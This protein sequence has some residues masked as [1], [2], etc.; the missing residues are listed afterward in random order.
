[1]DNTTKVVEPN[2]TAWYRFEYTGDHSQID[3]E[4]PDAIL[5]GVERGLAFEV[6]A[7]SQMQEWWK[8]D[9]VGAGS[10]K[11]DDLVWSG[12]SHEPGTWWIK[13]MNTKPTEMPFNLIVSGDKVSFGPPTEPVTAVTLPSAGALIENAVPDMAMVVKAN[14][15]VIPGNTTAWYRFPYQGG[16]DQIMLKIPN[17]ADKDLGVYI[18]TPE[19]VKEWWS[20]T[21]VGAATP[22]DGDLLWSGNAEEAGTGTS[23]WSTI[24]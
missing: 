7:P 8:Y 22:K 4:L 3:I 20:A 12:N 17:G 23:K 14:E 21:P 16:H 1:M 5:S 2:G 6:Y 19:Q 24:I 11:G 9:G 15:Q 18:L 10:P 13:V